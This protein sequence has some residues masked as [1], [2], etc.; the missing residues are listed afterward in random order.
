MDTAYNLPFVFSIN[1]CFSTFSKIE[2][3]IY[4]D[5]FR[6]FEIEEN[7][8]IDLL[9]DSKD[10]DARLYLEALDIL[11]DEY[12]TFYDENG[13]IYRSPSSTKI[14]L[15]R[16]D[17]HYDA[18]RVDSFRIKI[19]CQ[20]DTYYS[21]LSVL[22]KQLSKTE[23]TMMR[24]DLENEIVGLAQDLVRRNIGLGQ[25]KAGILPPKK[26][27]RFFILKKYASKILSALIDLNESPKH[28][29]RT[30]YEYK[31]RSKSTKIDNT[32]I[33]TYL[34]R[35][36]ID[37]KLLVPIKTVD[38][39]I[40]ENRLLKHIISIYDEELNKF[41][42]IVR[43]IQ[44]VQ[45]KALKNETTQYR[46]IYSEGLD[47][48]L[49]TAA[50]LL[51]ITHLV[52]IQ[53]WY[54]S[55]SQLTDGFVPHSFAL[56]SRYGVFYKMYEE[57]RRSDVK[58]QLDPKYSYSWKRS[59]YLYEMWCFIKICRY[60]FENYSCQEGSWN[61]DYDDR[62][63]F[64][65]LDE[66]TKMVF[67]NSET[68]LVIVYNQ[69][70]PQSPSKTNHSDC[71]FYCIGK[72]NRPDI[73]INIYSKRT[74]TYIGSIILEC[75]YRKLK[76]FWSSDNSWN[77]RP[78]IHSYYVDNKSDYL[79]GEY[80][81]IFDSRN[82][83]QVV[84]LTPDFNGNDVKQ[85]K[86]NILIKTLRPDKGTELLDGVMHIINDI[87]EKQLEKAKTLNM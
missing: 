16:N 15:Y 32:T 12:G 79:F 68:R 86:E 67:E 37:S 27:Y 54:Q 22:P 81:K 87:V 55:V 20:G 25:N 5:S 52:K 46:E 36:G 70:V 6:G 56:D 29:I 1:N 24:D 78:Q 21:L 62:L 44:D 77:S 39:D 3:E 65:I 31:D 23:W 82:V 7:D 10:S 76:S 35:G 33:Q 42:E 53:D 47:S 26:V 58:V 19:K 43:E 51:K 17:S 41:I 71:P 83:C 84:V 74:N 2:E 85:Q 72:H 34:K 48:F 9:F 64:P 73:T 61:M 11:P 50:Q 80:S 59:S 18:L 57:L 30:V 13:D 40:Q 49:E 28:K 69:I 63:L 4:L 66:K 60:L 14:P 45:K 38:Y 75:K 8:E